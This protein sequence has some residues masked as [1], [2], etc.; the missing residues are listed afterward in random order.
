M[1]RGLAK[2]HVLGRV[3]FH[4]AFQFLHRVALAGMNFGPSLPAATGELLVLDRVAARAGRRSAVVFDVGA[5]VGEYASAALGE[6]DGSAVL[7]SDARASP[8]A[9][10]FLRRTDHLPVEMS[11]QE[12]VTVRRLDDVCHEHEIDRIDLLKL[13]VEGSELRVLR[14]A[15]RLLK[16][17]RIEAIQFE[18]GGCNVDS[19]TFFRDFFDLLTPNYRLY[20]ILR[21]GVVPIDR[22]AEEHEVFLTVNYFAALR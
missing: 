13:D 2:R 6:R 18:F 3:R 11:M 17:G 7:H 5:N 4:G 1:L 12:M 21:D 15:D 19:R 14:G 22:Y 10:L 16:E 9:S 8:L 20:R